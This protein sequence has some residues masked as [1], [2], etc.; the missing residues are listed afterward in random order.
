MFHFFFFSFPVLLRFF[1]VS[2]F[3]W[4]L[5]SF[6]ILPFQ[7]Y[8][9]I[10]RTFSRA[11]PCTFRSRESRIREPSIGPATSSRLI[12]CCY[13][14]CIFQVH[15]LLFLD[16]FVFFLSSLL[17]ICFVTHNI[18]LNFRPILF[19]LCSLTPFLS[20]S[21]PFGLIS[22]LIFSLKSACHAAIINL[23]VEVLTFGLSL[24]GIA[25]IART[26]ANKVLRNIPYSKVIS[27]FPPF[28]FVLFYSV[29]GFFFFFLLP[30]FINIFI[31]RYRDSEEWLIPLRMQRLLLKRHGHLWTSLWK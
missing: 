30:F 29:F 20:I 6:F 13:C 7:F 28:I 27:F 24:F 3:G 5:F 17:I 21:Y 8:C 9:D 12:W 11:I 31:C 18:H 16:L 15:V 26:V 22:S 4:G 19:L 25:G 2:F 23:C 14:S 10:P 1:S